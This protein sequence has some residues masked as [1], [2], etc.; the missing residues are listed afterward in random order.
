MS[1]SCDHVSIDISGNSL[2]SLFQKVWHCADLRI[3]GPALKYFLTGTVHLPRIDQIPTG[4]AIQSVPIDGRYLGGRAVDVKL[5][6]EDELYILSPSG[7]VQLYTF[8]K[9]GA[10]VTPL[11][12]AE[13]LLRRELEDSGLSVRVTNILTLNTSLRKR[14]P[15]RINTLGDLIERSES[16]LLNIQGFGNTSLRE[17]RTILAG[18]GLSLLSPLAYLTKS[19]D[20]LG[21]PVR[22]AN[23]LKAD[24]ITLIG[25]LIERTESQLR[26]G[27]NL[28]QKKLDQIK[29]ALALRDLSLKA[30]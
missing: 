27:T 17:V 12:E 6:P 14:T 13:K 22:V 18:L 8:E 15:W 19:I 23:C 29:A 28:E 21:L 25:Q 3:R 16:D 11:S 24:N 2:Y 1:I 20:E 5:N 30:E 7:D 9:L 26:S 10:V 4:Y